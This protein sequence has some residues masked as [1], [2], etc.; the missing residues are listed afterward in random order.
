MESCSC[1]DRVRLCC[2]A[3]ATLRDDGFEVF[4]RWDVFV[5][6]GLAGQRPESFGGLQLWCVGRREDEAE[7][8]AS[9][10]ERQQHLEERL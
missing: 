10:Q 8:P 5:D 3:G 1:F 2:E 4:D 6:V 7:A 9:R